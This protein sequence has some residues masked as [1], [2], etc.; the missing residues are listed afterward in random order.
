MESMVRIQFELPESKVKELEEMMRIGDVHT[1]K[2]LFNNA[3]TLLQWAIKEVRE[4]KLIA[5]VD[6][7]NKK[8][9]ELAMPIFSAAAAKSSGGMFD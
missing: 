4:G 6:E 1:R 8:Y 9:K 7:Q 3:L 2:D 5:S